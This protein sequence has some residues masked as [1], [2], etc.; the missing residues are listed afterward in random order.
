MQYRYT[1]YPDTSITKLRR[2]ISTFITGIFGTN[3]N[4]KSVEDDRSK[5]LKLTVPYSTMQT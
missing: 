3:F 5:R 1:L 4:Y 2:K